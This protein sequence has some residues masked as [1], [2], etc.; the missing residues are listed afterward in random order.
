MND[1]QT[2]DNATYPCY[3]QRCVDVGGELKLTWWLAEFH[4]WVEAPTVRAIVELSSTGD[5]LTV[6]MTQIRFQEP[7]GFNE[8]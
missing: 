7:K 2:I 3:V 6:D 4:R 8:R 1:R 5:I